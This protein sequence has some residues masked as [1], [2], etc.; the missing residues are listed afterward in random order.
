M[1]TE[2]AWKGFYQQLLVVKSGKFKARRP[3]TIL[4]AV[5]PVRRLLQYVI[6]Y[7]RKFASAS[8]ASSSRDRLRSPARP[9]SAMPSM[10]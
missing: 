9:S 1:I 8:P 3:Q 4:E 6:R 5:S 7:R 2:H 10:T